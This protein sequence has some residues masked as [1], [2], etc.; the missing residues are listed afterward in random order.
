MTVSDRTPSPTSSRTPRGLLVGGLV[1]AFLIA[2][3]L[4]GYASG[5]PD[6]LERVAADEGFLESGQDSAVAG[7][8][9]ADYAVSGIEDPRLAGGLAG[10]IGV[11][12]V[13]AVGTLLFWAV[14]RA[15]RRRSDVSAD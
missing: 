8:P 13:L 5:A 10:L 3:F 11:V 2:G 14:S 4:S 6:G 1:L 12:L 9:L 7:S 15:G